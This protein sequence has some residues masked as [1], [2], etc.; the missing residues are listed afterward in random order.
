[1]NETNLVPVILCGGQGSRLWPLSRKNYPKQ[2][3]NLN[4]KSDKSLLQQTQQRIQNI[5]RLSEPII[6]CNESHRFIVAEQMREINVKPNSII[7]ETFAKN[8]APAIALAALKSLEAKTD[9]TLIVLASDQLI[10]NNESFLKSLNSATKIADKNKII[11]FGIIPTSAET[12]YGYIESVK[13]LNL[14]TLEG[15]DIVRFIEKPKKSI[16]EKFLKDDRYSWN[17]GMF[18]F[19]ASVILKELEIY[20]PE[21]IECCRN[22]LNNCVNDLDF[23]R[24]NKKEFSK[25]PSISIDVA[26][27]EK[28]K[29]GS[30][31][32][33]N[34]EWSDIG[35]FKSLW[36]YEEKNDQGNLVQGNVFLKNVKDSFFRSED[37]LLVGFGV[38]DLIAIDTFD[39]TFISKKELSQEVKELVV[40]MKKCGI[41]EA[42]QNKKGFRP[43]GSYLSI[44]KDKSWQVKILEVS[45]G[46]SLS[47][48]KHH[49]R[50]EHWVVVQGTALVKVG[51]KENILHENQSTYIPLGV[52]H[53]LSNPGKSI[54]RIIEVQSGD[55]LGE[56]DI[57][58]YKDQYGR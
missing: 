26:V 36:E 32:P 29:I 54:L 30:V 49:H 50:A 10:K 46:A 39:A 35:T 47:L 7:L 58:R 23:I 18:V 8:T 28:T 48:Q 42:S 2:F 19:K 24:L 21:I 22:S 44:A 53:Q 38:K 45:V 57:V 12:G 55:Y 37:K 4:S 6:I 5:K 15:S 3:L 20:A 52:K 34:A 25:C 9:P 33:L 31:V 40:E 16:A 27:M 51:E 14:K 41:N 17:S 43:W 1:M 11:T 56:D 13:N